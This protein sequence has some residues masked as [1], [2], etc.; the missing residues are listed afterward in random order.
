MQAMSARIGLVILAGFFVE[1]VCA[2]SLEAL[3]CAQVPTV[4][5]R[6]FL[7]GPEGAEGGRPGDILYRDIAHAIIDCMSKNEVCVVG[8]R[9]K[10]EY[11]KPGPRVV[12]A[13]SSASLGGGAL[14]GNWEDDHDVIS[15]AAIQL[16]PLQRN[17]KGVCMVAKNM[18]MTAVPWLV[19]AW[20]ITDGQSERYTLDI[21]DPTAGFHFGGTPQSIVAT[22][23]AAWPDKFKSFPPGSEYKKKSQSRTKS[24]R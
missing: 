3:P 6:E 12:Q 2:A 11:W 13:W 18:F 10:N 23:R 24:D 17:G 8:T 15:Y 4:N 22:M 14:E 21:I 19:I 9:S 16:L 5:V 20:E 7:L 1:Q